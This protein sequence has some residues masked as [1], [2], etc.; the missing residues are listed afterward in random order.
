[1]KTLSLQNAEFLAG[2]R[3]L[4]H[5][6][7]LEIRPGELLALVGAN[8]AGKSTLL[9][10]LSGELT[11]ARGVVQLEGRALQDWSPRERARRLAVLPQQT[12]VP[13]ALTALELVLLGRAPHAPG[14]ETPRDYEIALQ[15]M[16]ATAVHPFADREFPSLS[17]GEKARVQLARV[18]AQIWEPVGDSPR[19]LLLD[20]PNAALDFGH[21][22]RVLELART[23]AARGVGVVAILH[24]LNLASRYANRIVMLREGRLIAN[25]TPQEVL[26]PSTVEAAFGWR[27]HIQP[28]P[29]YDY[30][31]V[32]LLR[33]F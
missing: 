23:W 18:L 10:L 28:H 8:G 6:I 9:R 31:T 3:K 13:F 20:E 21:Q 12:S 24:D 2:K 14:G 1:M 33:S 30:P 11:P 22:H 19:F 5:G 7:D 26:T 4:L 32:E 17:G 16:Q 15:A 29:R 27:T 25:G